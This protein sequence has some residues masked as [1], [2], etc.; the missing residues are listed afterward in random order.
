MVRFYVLAAQNL[1]TPFC[2][3]KKLLQSFS[4]AKYPRPCQWGSLGDNA[5]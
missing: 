3:A 2:K 5:P 1:L 4:S